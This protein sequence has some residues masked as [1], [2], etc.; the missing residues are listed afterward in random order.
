MYTFM[1]PTTFIAVNEKRTNHEAVE[2]SDLTRTESFNRL[3]DLA[4]LFS[5]EITK[6]QPKRKKKKEGKKDNNNKFHELGS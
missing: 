2:S 6:I 5:V 1:D 4:H 3:N